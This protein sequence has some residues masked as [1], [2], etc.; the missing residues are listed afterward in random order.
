[1]A[2]SGLT[3]HW[4]FQKL[5]KDF[6]FSRVIAKHRSR[7]VIVSERAYCNLRNDTNEKMS[8]VRLTQI[9]NCEILRNT[10]GKYFNCELEICNF[11]KR[12]IL[13][14]NDFNDTMH[15][16]YDRQIAAVNH[17]RQTFHLTNYPMLQL[18]CFN[19]QCTKWNVWHEKRVD[20]S[21][22][23]CQHCCYSKGA[24]IKI[25]HVNSMLLS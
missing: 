4:L 6:V 2:C 1:M 3:H 22:R 15:W 12:V 16:L 7:F 17:K 14:I 20:C 25:A 5:E 9:G 13:Q 23:L 10:K 21:A 19:H 11:R 24:N 8:F 18:C